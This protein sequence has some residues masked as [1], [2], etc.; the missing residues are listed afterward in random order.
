MIEGSITGAVI[1]LNGADNVTID[2][3]QNG[4]GTARDL[5]V[6]NN[7]TATATAAIWLSSVAAGNGASNNTIRNLELAAGVDQSSASTNVTFGIAMSGTALT[8]TSNGVDNDNNSF[9]ANRIIR[10]RYGIMTRG[11]TTDL[12]INPVVTGNIVGPNAFGADQIGKLG[13]YMQADTGATVSGNTVQFVGCLDPQACTGSD[14]MGI[15]IGND[16]WSMAPGTITSNTYTVTKNVIHDVIEEL[17][18]SSVGL[19]L[20]TTGGGTATNNLVANNFI[21]NVR[22]NGTSGDQAVGLGIA[23]GHS[24]KVVYN[25]IIMTGDVDPGVSGASTNFGSGIRIANANGTTH[26]NL[27]LMNNSVYMDLSSSSGPTVR[28][29][30]ISGNSAAYVFGTGG[31]NF[32]NYYINASNL[33]SQTGGL[34]TVSGVTLTTQFA[35]LANWQAAYTAAQDA[36]SKQADP[37]HSSTTSDPHLLAGSPNIDMGTPIAGVTD[38]IDLQTRPNGAGVDIGADEYV[39]APGVLQLSSSTYSGNEGTTLVAT[40][41]RSLGS[42]GVVGATYTLGGGTATGGASCTGSTD[43][44]NPGPQLLSFPDGVTSQPINVTLCSDAIIDALETFTITLSNPTGGA[45]LGAQTVA[46]ATIGDVPP[47]FAGTFDVGTGQ[48]YTSLTNPGGIFEGLNTSGATGNVTINITSDLTGENGAV[49][50]NE[51]AGGFTVTIKPSGGNRSITGSSTNSIIRLNGADGVTIEGS[52]TGGTAI[53][54]GGDPLLRNLT[55]TNTNPTA[56]AGAVVAIMQGANSANNNTVRNVNINGQDPTQTLIGIH[57]GGNA[58]GSAPTV[59]SNNNVIV[60]NCAFQRSFIGIFNDGVSPAIPATGNVISHNDISATGVNRMRRAGM[61]LFNH[62]GIFV[63]ENKIGGIVSDEAADAIG[64]IAGIQNVTTTSVTSGGM[65]NS[66]ISRNRIDMVTSTNTT[67]FSAVGIAIAGD[68]LGPNTIVNNMITGLNAPATSPDL[69]AGIY[70]SGVPSATTRLY[71]NSV[72]NTGSRGAVAS[73]IGSYGIAISGTD[74]VVELKNNIFYTTQ[75]S[76]GGAAAKSY[77]IG[78]T[79]TVFTNLDSNY[80]AFFSSGANAG[81]FRTGSIDTT[82]T[83]LANLA[84]WQAAVSDDANSQEVDP[85]FVDPITNVHLQPASPVENDGTPIPAVIIDFDGNPRSVTAPEIG[86]DE[87]FVPVPGTLA[88]SS[89]TYTIG[90]AGPSATLTV[91]RTV[92]SDGAVTV[93]YALAG[94]TATGGAACGGA[95]DYVNTGGTVN[96]ANGE[97]T[98]N[99]VVPICD[100]AVFEGD[101]TFNATLSNATGGATIGTPNP[102]AVTITDNEIAMPG[103]LQMSAAFASFGEAAGAVTVSVTRTGGS[104]GAVGVSYS[105]LPLTANG[106]AACAAGVDFAGVSGTLNWA[107][108]DTAAKNIP[109]SICEDALVESPETFLVALATPTGGATI[110]VQSS[111]MVTINDNDVGGPLTINVGTGETYTSLTNAGGVFDA[112]NGMTISGNITVNVTSDLTAETGAIALNEFAAGFTMVIKPSGGARTISGTSAASSGLIILNGADNVTIDGSTSGGTD[113]SLTITNATTTSAVIWMRSTAVPNG[114]NSNTI[115]NTNLQGSVATNI[116]AG[117]L[118]GSSTFGGAAQAPQSNNT[119]QNNKVIKVQN[120]LFI[121]GNA[122]TFDQNWAI[123]GNTF[124]STV[125]SEKLSFRG[126]LLGGANNFTISGNTIMGISSTTVTSSTMTGIQLSANATN[127]TVTRNSISDVKHNNPSGFGANGIF[128][129]A[130]S[131][132]S[133]NLI[134]NNFI[135]D[136]A[137][138]GFNGVAFADNGYGI[139]AASGSGYKIYFNSINLATS[140]TTAN[141][142]TSAINI[143]SGVTTAGAVDVRDNVLVNQETVGTRFAVINESTQAAAVFADSNYNDY[144]AQNVGRQAT[145]TFATLANWQGATT[146]DANS[147]AVDPLFVSATDLHLQPA[148]TILDDGSPLASVTVDFDGDARSAT[149]PDI[150]ADEVAGAPGS[151]AFSSATYTIGEAGPTA[152]LTVNRTGGSSGAVTVDYALGGGTATGGGSCGGA[153][154]YVNTGGTLMFAD[155]ET[156]KTISVAICD[157]SVF[158]GDETFNATLSN[159]TGGA[160]IGTPNPAAVTITE[161]EGVP[162]VQFSSATYTTV[163]ELSGGGFI[164]ITLSGASQSNV[165]VNYATVAGS[166][167]TGGASC[168]PGVDYLNTSGTAT[169]LAGQVSAFFNVPTCIDTVDEPDETV[170]LALT[171]PVGATLGSPSTAVL[172]L[173]D[174]DVPSGPTVLTVGTGGTYPSLTNTG[175]VFEFINGM[176]VTNDLVINI[177]SDLAGETGTVALNEFAAPFTVVIKPTGAARTITGS[178]TTGIIK[179]NGADRVTIDGSLTGGTATGVG[180]DPALRNLTVQNTSTTATAGGVIL[181]QQGTNGAQDVTIKNVNVSGQDPTQTLLGIHFGNT[182]PGASPTINNNNGRVENCSVQKAILGIFY[183][184]VT[185]TPATGAVITR[186][187]LSATGANRLRRGGIFFFNQNGIQVTENSI[188]GIDSNESADSI[189]IIAGIQN[190]S[191]TNVT[192]GG[193]TNALIAGNKISGITASSTV[194]FSAAGIA[195][196]GGTTGPNTIQ[197]N[198]ISGVIGPATSPDIVAG[199][200]VAGVTSSTTRVLYNSVWNTGNRGAVASQIGSYGIAISGTNPIVELKNNAISNTQTSGGGANAKS[201]S[202]GMTSTTFTNLDSNFNDWFAGG[203]NVGFFRT[204]SLD[205][206]GTD[207]GTLA[208]WQAAVSDDANSQLIDPLFMSTTDLHLQL[209]S[210]I[211]DDG[212]PIAGVTT[213][214]DGQTRS[215]TTPDIGADEVVGGGAPGSLQFSSATYSVGEA[216]GTSTITVTRTGGSTGTVGVTFASSNGTATGGASC[217]AGVDYVNANGTL[218]FLD[219]EVSKTFDVTICNDAVFE[220]NET[221][222][223]ALSNVTGGATIGSPSTAVLTIT[224]DDPAPATFNVSISD[225]HRAEGNSGTT[226]AVFNVTLSFI[227]PPT[228]APEGVTLASVQY[229]TANGTATAGSDYTA[230]SGTLNFESPG[231]LTVSVPVTGDLNKEENEFFFVNLSN[232]SP[233]TI[234]VD[235]QGAGVLVDE[236]RPYVADFDRDL[237]SDFSVFRPSTSVWY[238][239]QS[240]NGTNKIGSVGPSG[241]TAVPGDYDGDGLTD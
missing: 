139:V 107:D 24:D 48:S 235:G 162:T 114:S 238:V 174:N 222:N 220:G 45:T 106:A 112:I 118:A 236:D 192:S 86:A 30:A 89:A 26:L 77:A 25:T 28:F 204:G 240:S 91:N 241:M 46:T 231:T 206:T 126:M 156:S 56:T 108:G 196:A 149:T 119:F 62:N 216:G 71:Y 66:I 23:G 14:R 39:A 55:V 35:T 135:R 101:E 2:G 133:N 4:A 96:F 38:D 99:I 49:A 153:V 186:N 80:N 5:T 51:L 52:L 111:E 87:F 57:I 34:G 73:Q 64:I 113:R 129:A 172:T 123:T 195:V 215:A 102:A 168:T 191:T 179:F 234:I 115:K 189:G 10:A 141:S 161:N 13:I 32:N 214:F 210:P 173:L 72:S 221:V 190:V 237:K 58:P 50:L 40:V 88:F 127:G 180:G 203:A 97:T 47:P 169:I 1:R 131:V 103:S 43:Y 78:M 166:S 98:K 202:I 229:A 233:N 157:D 146:K 151:L 208:A 20:A 8:T 29:Y 155:A 19:N 219:A 21:Y 213:D 165:T 121:S 138:V 145:V 132:A 7:S 104:N 67:G 154:D 164:T 160:T 193:V 147:Q 116:I 11:T 27:T 212:T 54:V 61:F 70:V 120:A 42:L 74:P 226:N 137:G 130:T 16:A 125:V 143:T 122:T 75:T 93:D 152:T 44:I 224:D 176:T 230:T 218:T 109:I 15:S 183:N 177:V 82:G 84:A 33:Q 211:L 197:N 217:G 170:N 124:G 95:V 150:G 63:T 136:I 3:R 232:P 184:G 6:R 187:D 142:I 188:G 37:L 22:T 207:L 200:F 167:A 201:Y 105:F 69:V 81:G 205:T 239:L 128:L 110:G 12:N 228:A 53:G 90:E 225:V 31:E 117:V 94:G 163:D 148:S 185:G 65:A 158:E 68:P 175:G 76:G 227:S 198:M 209:G 144:F 159:A 199:I 100:D 36:N 17:T 181:V 182:N 171:M 83:D 60:D 9:I 18:F 41:N 140:Q 79:T 223:L 59:A 85:L 134:S 178:S 194:G 92:G